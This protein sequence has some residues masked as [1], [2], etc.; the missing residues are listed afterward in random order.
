V[1]YDDV[2]QFDGTE[3]EVHPAARKFAEHIFG[4]IRAATSIPTGY[5]L[6]SALPCRRRPG[7]RKCPGWI[8]IDRQ[9]IPPHVNWECSNCQDS[10]V[11]H[12][13]EDSPYDLR[14]PRRLDEPGLLSIELRDD[15]HAELRRLQLLDLD[16]E[17]VVW[18]AYRAAGRLQLVGTVDDLDNLFGFIAFEANHSENRRRQRHLDQVIGRLEGALRTLG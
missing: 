10:G 7:H 1:L 2:T 6:E 4:V 16:S 12:H 14:P 17:R 15:E 18:S 3:P 8:R 5:T 11:I 13:W 9:D